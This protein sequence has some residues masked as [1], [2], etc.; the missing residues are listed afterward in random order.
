MADA[1]NLVV[2]SRGRPL[3]GW[4]C[5]QCESKISDEVMDGYPGTIDPRFKKAMCHKCRKVKV[6]KKWEQK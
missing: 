1:K 5:T 6:I 4:H 2:D 3:N